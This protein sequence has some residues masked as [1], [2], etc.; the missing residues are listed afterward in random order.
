M[1]ATTCYAC[2]SA[3]KIEGTS[4][5]LCT[6]NTCKGGGIFIKCGFCKE[7]A[8][9]VESNG[10]AEKLM[11]WNQQCRMYQDPR[12]KCPVCGKPG[13]IAYND[14]KICIN[15]ACPENRGI[16]DHCW[17]CRQRNPAAQPAFLNAPGLMFCTK[18]DCS[19]MKVPVADCPHCG[20]RTFN[21]KTEAC[22]NPECTPP[23]KPPP[24]P[25][26][27]TTVG[28]TNNE[29]SKAWEA[30]DRETQPA[31]TPLSQQP[32]EP[33]LPESQAPALAAPAAT[34]IVIGK[35]PAEH[36]PSEAGTQAWSPKREETPPQ[37]APPLPVEHQPTSW[38]TAPVPPP[39]PQPTGG[40]KDAWETAPAV[41]APA[42]A[43]LWDKPQEQQPAAPG[44]GG[45]WGPQ[46]Q[47]QTAVTPAPAGDRTD[48][49]PASGAAPSDVEPQVVGAGSDI[50]EAYQFIKDYLIKDSSGQTYPLYLVIGLAGA[51]KTTYLTM[52]GD[53]LNAKTDKY[54]FPYPGIDIREIT[55]ND[56]FKQSGLQ[57]P[58]DKK[59]RLR[60]RIKDLVQGFA[61]DQFRDHISKMMWADQTPPEEDGQ[62]EISSHFLVC[63]LTRKGQTFARLITVE[64]SGEDYRAMIEAL[65]QQDEDHRPNAMQEVLFDMLDLAEGFVIL[66]SPDTPREND[67]IFQHMFLRLKQRLEP[68][69]M[70]EYYDR[71]RQALNV[72]AEGGDQNMINMIK[73][74][75]SEAQ[76]RQARIERLKQRAEDLTG[77][78]ETLLTRLKDPADDQVVNDPQLEKLDKL[79]KAVFPKAYSEA[80][81]RVLSTNQKQMEKMRLF[82]K[83]LCLQAQKPENIVKLVKH[84]V[85]VTEGTQQQ[86]GK[87]ADIPSA[88][89]E[90]A[91]L[92]IAQAVGLKDFDCALDPN[93]QEPRIASR[94]KNLKYLSIVITKSDMN[95]VIHPPERYPESKM[96]KSYLHVKD[97][98]NYLRLLG[99]QIRYYNASVTGY[100]FMRDTRHYPGKVNTLTPINVI[101]PIFDMLQINDKNE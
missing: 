13:L 79:Y 68:R 95:P 47:P 52:L 2:G 85:E 41:Q 43:G 92:Q 22:D 91:R 26:D 17:F 4:S 99:G 100:S 1:A 65:H 55:V 19:H 11:C 42:G 72:A 59:R 97:I 36:K 94:M 74:L 80:Q 15:R 3:L 83:G 73:Q 18:S 24:T 87:L 31:A 10:G 28:S 90:K 66:I 12:E 69:A 20:Q 64:T 86:Q 56:I 6:N 48:E 62:E 71:L 93:L 46:P 16:I 39:E 89:L 8:C 101:E 49:P 38:P 61:L 81:Q 88:L 25:S 51:G 57:Y 29:L 75:T 34:P 60:A 96:Q 82:F 14:R 98:D 9:A 40:G 5:A 30:L 37:L 21:E 27:A 67:E 77:N 53:I 35:P 78:I 63:E 76:V 23:R 50:W 32:T 44:G 45:G 33:A 58:E 70:H 84:E 7:F 54:Y